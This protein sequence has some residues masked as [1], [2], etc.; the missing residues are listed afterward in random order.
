[1]QKETKQIGLDRITL[2]VNESEITVKE[3]VELFKVNIKDG[4]I[5]VRPNGVNRD[6]VDINITLPKLFDCTNENN[7]S[8]DDF[9]YLIPVIQDTLESDGV[10]LDVAN[11]RL[12]SFEVNFNVNDSKFYDV[13]ELI[14]KANIHDNLKAFKV[15]NKDGIQSVKIKKNKYTVKI[16]KKSEHLMETFK[17]VEEEFVVRFEVSTNN[18]TQKERLLGKDVTLQGLIENW[19][20]VEDWYKACIKNTIKKPVEKYVSD[21]EKQCTERLKQG[22]KPSVLANEMIYRQDMVDMIVFDNVMKKHYKSINKK[23][24]NTIKATHN[25]LK[26]LDETRYNQTTGNVSKLQELYDLIGV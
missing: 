8:V 10:L 20:T 17:P 1:M 6:K 15:E 26:K 25:R 11:A 2:T 16:Y 3:D 9:E 19:S 4:T 13:F 18:Y 21:M 22:V 7:V 14:S 12:G 24:T 5:V 23:P